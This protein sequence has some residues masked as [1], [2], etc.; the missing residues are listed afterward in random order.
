MIGLVLPT[1]DYVG[2]GR[3]LETLVDADALLVA[4]VLVGATAGLAVA[5]LIVA[6]SRKGLRFVALALLLLSL[7]NVINSASY[8]LWRSDLVFCHGGC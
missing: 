4:I 2:M 3:Q 7:W 8:Y 6:W 1:H 5:V